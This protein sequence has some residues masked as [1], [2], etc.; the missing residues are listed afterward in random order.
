MPKKLITYILSGLEDATSC[1]KTFFGMP[2]EFKVETSVK[3]GDPLSPLVYICVADALHAGWKDNPLYGKKTGY[4]FSIGS[5][6]AV[7]S[8]GY[9]DDAMIYAMSWEQIWMM[10]QWTLEF[11]KAHG[12]SGSIFI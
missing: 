10:H 2:N 11:C 4:K 5:S 3:Q 6:I 12:F 7:S 8:S 9:A 1:F